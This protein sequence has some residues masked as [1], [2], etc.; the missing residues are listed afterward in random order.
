MKIISFD[1]RHAIVPACLLALLL[2]ACG[3]VATPTATI[4]PSPVASDT[5]S[6]VQAEGTPLPDRFA[7]LPQSSSPSGFPQAGFPNA[8]VSV[9][10]YLSFGDPESTAFH[11]GSLPRLVERARSGEVL[12]TFVPLAGQSEQPNAQSAREAARAALCASEQNAFW[13]YQ[14]ALFTASGDAAASSDTFASDRLTELATRLNLNR[15]LWDDCMGS[16]RP[17]EILSEADRQVSNNEIFTDVPFVTI[18]GASSLLDVESLD[19][20]INLAVQQ[21][22]AELEAALAEGTEEATQEIIEI[23]AL[24]STQNEQ[25]PP[26]LI[27]GLPDGWVAGYDVIVLQDV[28]AIRNIPFAVYRGPVTGGTGNIV[29]LWG[30]PNLMLSDG[31]PSTVTP[32]L[33]LDGL[34]L[35]RLA[36]VESGCNIGTDL[37]RQY[38]VGG[39][40]AIGTQFAAVDC[41]ELEDTRGWFAG[42]RQY[43]LN[44]VFYVYT[45]PI[46]AMDTAEAEL[47]AILDSVRFTVPPTPDPNATP[48]S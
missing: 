7:S 26:P 46:G 11:T 35:L 15:A 28:D 34:R 33:W 6:P 10:I 38:N 43:N 24:P 21:F 8:P 40:A 3:G 30:F 1:K 47:Q 23:I 4:A 2:T 5:P 22:N 36:I 31:L 16:N 13:R 18:N 19:F 45:E 14:D 17:D 27:L 25:V 37:Q 48:G 42:L 44:Y 41:P 12:L 32:D 20:T 39:L 9:T 29:L